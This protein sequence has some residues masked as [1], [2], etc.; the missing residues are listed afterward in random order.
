MRIQV[1]GAGETDSLVAP[2]V[3]GQWTVQCSSNVDFVDPSVETS[4]WA[5]NMEAD[6]SSGAVEGAEVE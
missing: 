1:L 4:H 2:T 6:H 3:T 5:V